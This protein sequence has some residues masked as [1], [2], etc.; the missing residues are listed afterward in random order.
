MILDRRTLLAGITGSA[1]AMSATRVAEN[2]PEHRS[3]RIPP[4]TRVDY[5]SILSRVAAYGREEL[6]FWGLPG[7][8]IALTDADGFSAELTLGYADVARNISITSEQLFQIGSISK[9]FAAIALMT[10]VDEGKLDLELPLAS[11]LPALPLP[12]E[13]I[14]VRQ[15]LT[16]SS[17][18][19]SLAPIFPQGAER[20]LWCGFPPG[21]KFSY[22]NTGY[23][24]LGRLLERLGEQPHPRVIQQ[25]VLDPLGMTATRPFVLDRDRHRY[26]TGYAPLVVSRPFVPGQPLAPGPWTNFDGASGGV[27]ST[28]SDMGRYLRFLIAAARGRGTPVLSD[29][30]AREFTTSLIDAPGLGPAVRY[31]L[32]LATVPVNGKL[33]LHHTGGMLTFVSSL[34]VDDEAGGCFASV[35]AQLGNGYRPRAL[36]AYAVALLRAA[37]LGGEVATPNPG[38]AVRVRAASRLQGRYSAISGRQIDVIIRDG[39]AR[40]QFDQK[41]A[42]IVRI[43]DDMF[44]CD[45]P[46]FV[47]APFRIIREGGDVTDLW[48][49]DIRFHRGG[50]AAGRSSDRLHRLAGWYESADPWVGGLIIRAQDGRLVADSANSLAIDPI[51]DLA[52]RGRMWTTNDHDTTERLFFETPSSGRP[53]ILNYSGTDMYRM[54][55]GM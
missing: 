23:D 5:S 35:N 49:R 39:V 14:T 54:S 17:G 19:P 36:T 20:R 44:A 51:F 7:M 10:F 16:H 46:D 2:L 31:G 15:V 25:R 42:R 13:R 24:L 52:D 26:A 4:G 11:Y 3:I 40:L 27:A 37:R 28:A 55:S 18:L 33:C 1:S 30:S 32:G 6:D 34:H 41:D 50:P 12:P 21:T 38:D 53:M 45:H 9:S 47:D 22:S 29:A 43:D 8:T 48:W